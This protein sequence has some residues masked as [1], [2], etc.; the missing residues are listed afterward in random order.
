MFL[1]FYNFRDK[2]FETFLALNNSRMDDDELKKLLEQ[3]TTFE[4]D[5]RELNKEDKEK[6]TNIHAK[7]TIKRKCDNC[8]CSLSKSDTNNTS[9]Y[10]SKC[11]NCYLGDAFRCSGCPYKGMPAFKEGEEVKFDEDNLNDL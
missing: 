11:G 9:N 2:K 4:I 1:N 6:N 10:K 7:K 3:A 5:P 8:T